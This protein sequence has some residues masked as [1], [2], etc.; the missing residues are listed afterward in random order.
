MKLSCLLACVALVAWPL[1]ARAEHARIDLKLIHLDPD[2]GAEARGGQPP[3]PTRSR[4][5]EAAT[6]GRWRR[7]R[8][9]SRWRCNFS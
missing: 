7:S 8:P 3:P 1:S 2:S 6:N 9:A 4:R 5:R